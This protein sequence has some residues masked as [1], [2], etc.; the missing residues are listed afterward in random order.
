MGIQ[1]LTTLI[2]MVLVATA[3]KQAPINTETPCSRDMD[4]A[5]A[6]YDELMGD[7]NPNNDPTSPPRE[8][9]YPTKDPSSSLTINATL[10]SFSESDEEKMREALERLEIVV[11]SIEFK[12]RVINH[13]FNGENTF[14]DNDGLTNEEI[15]EKLM[16]GKEDLLPSVDSEMDL[17]MTLYYKN[18]S[19]VGYTYPDTLKIWVNKKF[20]AGYTYGQV[21]ANALHEWSH[22]VGF[23]HSFNNNASRPYSV[24]YAIG[25]IAREMVDAM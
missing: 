2:M 21:A 18:N 5:W 17:D 16:S 20:F 4:Q 9:M 1:K 13:I 23:T 19:T 6:E 7:D 14:N 8:C 24:P 11:N 12:E 22:K 3:C 10:R 25:T 15:Y